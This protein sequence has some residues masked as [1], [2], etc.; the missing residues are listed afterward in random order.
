[1]DKLAVLFIGWALIFAM[2]FLPAR[3]AT[4]WLGST[5]DSGTGALSSLLR[6][7]LLA[8]GFV[9]IA[10]LSLKLG[11]R[12]LLFPNLR[13]DY[14]GLLNVAIV[15]FVPTLFALITA[16]LRAR[17][18]AGR[19]PLWSFLP[20]NLRAFLANFLAL[21]TT[22]VLLGYWGWTALTWFRTGRTVTRPTTLVIALLVLVVM[23]LGLAVQ[24][25]AMSKIMK[26]VTR[27]TILIAALAVGY[28]IHATS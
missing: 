9:F 12:E 14:F 21:A 8:A 15:L 7:T 3:M 6:C 1:M 4:A 17:T 10:R 24:R 20:L 27:T 18:M 28:Y 19:Q 26:A 25:S 13:A 16:Y 2:L 22:L 5:H 23:G 11:G